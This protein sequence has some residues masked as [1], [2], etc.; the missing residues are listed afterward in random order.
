MGTEISRNVVQVLSHI[1]DPDTGLLSSITIQTS[2][3]PQESLYNAVA[4]IFMNG[5]VAL[6]HKDNLRLNGKSSRFNWHGYVKKVHDS[7]EQFIRLQSQAK[8]RAATCQNDLCTEFG[9]VGTGYAAEIRFSKGTF[10][11]VEMH[12]N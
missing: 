1:E 5:T 7:R 2:A 4:N 6:I 11:F 12:S 10:C 9:G 3:A 8:L